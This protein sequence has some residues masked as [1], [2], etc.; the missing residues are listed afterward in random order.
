MCLH[1][2][3]HGLTGW[4][5]DRTSWGCRGG[6]GGCNTPSLRRFSTGMISLIPQSFLNQWH[7]FLLI[8]PKILCEQDSL[9]FRQNF[10]MQCFSWAS[11]FKK[12]LGVAKNTW[13]GLTTSLILFGSSLVR[14]RYQ[15]E[16][17][18]ALLKVTWE[19]MISL[20]R[21]CSDVIFFP[22]SIET[23]MEEQIPEKSEFVKALDFKSV[24]LN[25]FCS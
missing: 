13:V 15:K 24:T 16:Q 11:F 19:G 5:A 1:A 7:Q 12:V 8:C 20:S 17:G 2:A 18:F 10:Y 21:F 9:L 4:H 23:L 6:D 3:G 22:S 25:N 14:H